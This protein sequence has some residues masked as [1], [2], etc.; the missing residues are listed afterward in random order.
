MKIIKKRKMRINEEYLSSREVLS[1][2]V[3]VVLFFF[4]E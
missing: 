1:T 4:K 3:D 2:K